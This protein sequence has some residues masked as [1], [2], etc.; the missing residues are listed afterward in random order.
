MV[1]LEGILGWDFLGGQGS[2]LKDGIGSPE[3]VTMIVSSRCAQATSRNGI[4]SSENS[5][6][7]RATGN[8]ADRSAAG[9]LNYRATLIS[10]CSGGRHRILLLHKDRSIGK[11]RTVQ[12]SSTTC[13]PISPKM[14]SHGND[15][16][17]GVGAGAQYKLPS[18]EMVKQA[19][20]VTIYDA[21]AKP[22]LF[23]SLY[24]SNGWRKRVMVIFIRHFFC[25]VGPVFPLYPH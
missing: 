17:V 25:G 24:S 4:E 3:V 13:F 16:D 18:K 19:G 6:R 10:S 8:I 5:R 1:E 15:A 22:I 23:K 2:I 14:S 11:G 20:E 7:L 21:A 12:P 9:R